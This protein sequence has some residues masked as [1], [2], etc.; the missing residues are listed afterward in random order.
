MRRCESVAACF[1]ASPVGF[2]SGLK[3]KT[4]PA[5]PEMSA[6]I[7]PASASVALGDGRFHRLARA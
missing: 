5:I 1:A 4:R 6:T 3:R 7:V 2:R